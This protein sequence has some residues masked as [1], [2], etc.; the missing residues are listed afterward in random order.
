MTLEIH[1]PLHLHRHPSP[2]GEGCSTPTSFALDSQPFRQAISLRDAPPQ[3]L[4]RDAPPRAFDARISSDAFP[5]AKPVTA[6][7]LA[8]RCDP[9]S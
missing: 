8:G 6:P 9:T 7:R 2:E 4:V 1:P 3:E 5:S